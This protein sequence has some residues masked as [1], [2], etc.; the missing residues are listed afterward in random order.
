MNRF[1]YDSDLFLSLKEPQAGQV[2]PTINSFYL[3]DESMFFF[4]S[5]H[6]W[7][8]TDCT[9]MN[10][11]QSMPIIVDILE[12]QKWEYKMNV[13]SHLFKFQLQNSF[14]PFK[15]NCFHY[16]QFFHFWLQLTT[17][18]NHAIIRL[19]LS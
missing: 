6:E 15:C 3:N 12:I 5:I 10:K 8:I 9:A 17:N 4:P 14:V 1:T 11:Y 2:Q 18:K 7:W 19:T 16:F 13:F